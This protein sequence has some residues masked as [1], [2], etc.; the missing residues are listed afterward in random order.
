MRISELPRSLLFPVPKHLV[1]RNISSLL[2][3]LYLG[4]WFAGNWLGGG[5]AIRGREQREGAYKS[6]PSHGELLE[7][8]GKDYRISISP[9]LPS[10]SL[11]PLS[12]LSLSLHLFLPPLE[13]VRNKRDTTCLKARYLKVTLHTSLSL[14]LKAWEDSSLLSLGTAPPQPQSLHLPPWMSSGASQQ[15]LLLPFLSS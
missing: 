1:C 13:A 3:V 15:D 8:W 11:H 10:L 6:S 9:S 5:K 14:P 12:L 4:D 2:S 7:D